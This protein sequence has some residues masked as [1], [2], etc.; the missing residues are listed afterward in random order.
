MNTLPIGMKDTREYGGMGMGI[1]EMLMPPETPLSQ[2]GQ[3]EVVEF[4][5]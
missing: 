4:A 2:I 3:T 1:K 5:C